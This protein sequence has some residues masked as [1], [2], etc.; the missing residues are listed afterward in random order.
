MQGGMDLSALESSN[1]AALLVAQRNLKQQKGF[2]PSWDFGSVQTT[3]TLT[4]S[5]ELCGAIIGKGGQNI[6]YVKQVSGATID[7]TKA[8]GDSER[9]VTMSGTQD[10]ITVAEQLMNQCIRSSKRGNQQ[11]Q[12]QQP[13]Q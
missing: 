8:D 5:N 11:Q 12:Q 7:M 13:H 9:T 4:L 10:Q 6:R 3:T 1:I 2:D